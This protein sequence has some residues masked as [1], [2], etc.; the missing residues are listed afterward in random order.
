MKV[1]EARLDDAEVRRTPV[2]DSFV[3]RP[4]FP[5]SKLLHGISVSVRIAL[6]TCWKLSSGTSLSGGSALEEAQTREGQEEAAAE[7]QTSKA[8]SRMVSRLVSR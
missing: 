5:S 6:T 3:R 8:G 2:A 1:L 4:S 7:S